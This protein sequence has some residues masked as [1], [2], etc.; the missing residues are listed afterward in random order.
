MSKRDSEARLCA[1]LD[2][3]LAKQGWRELT[4]AS[5]AQAA[6]LPWPELLALAPS[7]AALAGVFL[8]RDAREAAGRYKPERNSQ[9]AR[10][11][12]FDVCTTW[13]EVQQPH[14]KPMREFYRGIA[15]DPLLL[16]SARGQVIATAEWLLAL[17]EADLGN[18]TTAQAIAL[19]GILVRA[20]PVWLKDDDQMEKTMAQLDR[21]LRR[22]E[23][24]LWPR[25][26]SA[27]PERPDAGDEDSGL[28]P[29]GEPRRATRRGGSNQA[30]A[31]RRGRAQYRAL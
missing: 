1:A 26:K 5:V 31:R 15:R 17:A 2:R 29:A 18:S 3:L 9:I 24:F 10:E 12:V 13:F 20:I 30:S 16:L 27:Q 28:R 7:K 4:L 21:D 23:S 6:N 25:P 11:R 22:M 8:R 19:A 14:K